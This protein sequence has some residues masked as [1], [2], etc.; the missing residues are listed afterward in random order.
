MELLP[1][2]VKSRVVD[3]LHMVEEQ[4]TGP[5]SSRQLNPRP[6]EVSQKERQRTA[7]IVGVRLPNETM[8][9]MKLFF[10]S[11]HKRGSFSTAE[12]SM[13]TSVVAAEAGVACREG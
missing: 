7:P 13:S 9:K 8:T 11:D 12:C 2:L 6:R 4:S 1:E 5:I 3:G 10:A